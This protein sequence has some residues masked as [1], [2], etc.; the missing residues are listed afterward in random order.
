MCI[1]DVLDQVRHFLLCTFPIKQW[2]ARYRSEITS[3]KIGHSYEVK[4]KIMHLATYIVT[5]FLVL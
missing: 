5:W 2:N 4:A 1:F 3:V